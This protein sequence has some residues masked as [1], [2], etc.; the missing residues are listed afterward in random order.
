MSAQSKMESLSSKNELL[1]ENV[2]SLID[3]AKKT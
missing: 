2:S 1:K 3:E